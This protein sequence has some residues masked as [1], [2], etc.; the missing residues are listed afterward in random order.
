MSSSELS[1]KPSSG[2]WPADVRHI[3][4]ASDRSV[5]EVDDADRRLA[6]L[7]CQP[8]SVLLPLLRMG[9]SHSPTANPSRDAGDESNNHHRLGLQARVQLLVLFQLRP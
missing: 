7:G 4:Q 3:V 5:D 8:V 9:R 6:E 2:S 1:L